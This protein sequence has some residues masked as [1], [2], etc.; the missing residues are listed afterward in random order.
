MNFINFFGVVFGDF[1]YIFYADI[2]ILFIILF[3]FQNLI[4]ILYDRSTEI[5]KKIIF[6]IE[7]YIISVLLFFFPFFIVETGDVL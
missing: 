2:S 1:A 3:I 6:Y 4:L 7:S 5:F